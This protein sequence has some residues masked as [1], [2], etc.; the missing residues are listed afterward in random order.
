MSDKTRLE[1]ALRAVWPVLPTNSL[2]RQLHKTLNNGDQACDESQTLFCRALLSL[3]PVLS[4]AKAGCIY[5]MYLVH[6][7]CQFLLPRR[8]GF[9]VLQ[10]TCARCWR[11]HCPSS[12]TA[13]PAASPIPS[14]MPR[15][16][17]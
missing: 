3:V 1:G 17:T 12:Q 10:A 13:L 7:L 11:T 4:A 5:L 15:C 9:E 2:F 16:Y 6:L 14:G 8:P